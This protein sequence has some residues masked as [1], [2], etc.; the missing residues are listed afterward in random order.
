[1]LVQ[2]AAYALLCFV[3]VKT[4]IEGYFILSYM[5]RKPFGSALTFLLL[6][7][8]YA[9]HQPQ[10]YQTGKIISIEQKQNTE[11]LYYQVNTPITRDTPYFEISIQ[12]NDFLY[13]GQYTPRHSADNL[14]EDWKVGSEVP[15]RATKREMFVERPEG[16]ELRF[17]IEKR[18]S[19][20]NASGP[21]TK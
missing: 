1:M 6:S 2:A 13:V 12:I 3:F 10:Q 7:S 9:V 14:P 17:A 18:S 11:V 19:V 16:G 5:L 15:V 20:P 21:A 8:L 4:P